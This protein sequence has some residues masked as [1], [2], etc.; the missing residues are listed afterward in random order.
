MKVNLDASSLMRG[1]RFWALEVIDGRVRG[2]AHYI[3]EASRGHL[4][5]IRPTRSSRRLV[6]I[7]FAVLTSLLAGV[8]L[9]IITQFGFPSTLVSVVGYLIF[10]VGASVMALE[11]DRWAVGYLARHAE[12][13]FRI[14]VQSAQL[15]TY[16]HRLLTRFETEDLQLRVQGLPSRLRTALRRG[17]FQ[18]Y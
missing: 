10:F 16:F 18:S 5:I 6:G 17:G 11:V 13:S 7:T 9:S 12:H 4:E 1:S 14:S 3:L 8:L 2:G 15:G